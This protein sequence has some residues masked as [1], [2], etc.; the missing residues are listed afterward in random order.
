VNRTLAVLLVFA[1]SLAVG[2][3]ANSSRGFHELSMGFDLIHAGSMCLLLSAGVESGTFFESLTSHQ[4]QGEQTFRVGSEEV[5]FYP[6]HVLLKLRGFLDTC[7]PREKGRYRSDLRLDSDFMTSLQFKTHSKHGFDMRTVEAKTEKKG[8][9]ADP[10][11]ARLSP[12][13]DAWEYELSIASEDVPL[14][15]SLVLLILDAKG[16][17]LSR[18]SGRV[19]AR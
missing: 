19:R 16:T 6:E 8:R 15:D 1:A 11:F 4:K 9:I 18:L 10:D 14:T 5:R 12:S 17:E 7:G 2:Q 3:S 13:T